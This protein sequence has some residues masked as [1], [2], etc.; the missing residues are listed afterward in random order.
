MTSSLREFV[1]SYWSSEVMTNTHSTLSLLTRD[2][3]A[4]SHGRPGRALLDELERY[5]VN[6]LDA[7]SAI[8]FAL[9]LRIMDDEAT[10]ALEEFL[11]WTSVAP[12]FQ[13]VALVALTPELENI[14][15]RF[16]RRRRSSDLEAEIISWALEALQWTHELVDGE[17]VEFVLRH[18]I[19][20][21]RRQRRMN[22]RHN[23]QTETLDHFTELEELP[24]EPDE[25]DFEMC[26]DLALERGVISLE[27]S[28]LIRSTRSPKVNLVSLARASTDSYDALR[29]RRR[30]AEARVRHFSKMLNSLELGC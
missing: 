24:Y 29:M 7:G 14:T 26:L 16:A 1:N 21:V 23:I 18:V 13:L 19:S 4:R 27:E 25:L 5:R 20:R 6:L 28:A 15:E 17:R 10:F 12:N 30:R 8:E 9:R 3:E 2:L 11:E 22:A